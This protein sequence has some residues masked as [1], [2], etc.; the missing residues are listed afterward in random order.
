MSKVVGTLRKVTLDGVTY[1]AAADAS[2]KA[3]PSA[4]ENTSV[5]TSGA[6]VRKMVKRA[7]TRESVTLIVGGAE[8]AALKALA[9]RLDDFPMSYEE[10]NGDTY[11]ATG[12]IEFESYDTDTGIATI[13]MEP[14]DEWAAFLN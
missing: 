6:N 11:T 3:M 2:I 13:K 12:F 7:Q 14:R 9:E 4:F 10:A 5:P 8:Q 1:D